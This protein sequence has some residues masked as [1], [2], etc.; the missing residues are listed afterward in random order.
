VLPVAAYVNGPYGIKDLYV[1]VPAV[2][3]EKG[4]ERIVELELTP[5]EKAALAKSSESVKTL[6][7]ACKEL[8]PRLK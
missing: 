8:D 1:G 3:G 5:D 6:I 4:V 2:I 7:E